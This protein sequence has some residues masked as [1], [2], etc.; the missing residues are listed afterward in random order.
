M[1]VEF[2]TESETKTQGKIT[3]THVNVV[4]QTPD[5]E[6]VMM[7]MDDIKALAELVE[8]NEFT[9]QHNSYIIRGL[10]PQGWKTLKGSNAPLEDL[11]EYYQDFV[12]HTTK[13]KGLFQVQVIILH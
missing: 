8:N 4:Q 12:K 9:D 7:D 13:F 10:T 2:N 3:T 1:E 5:G 6:G 11:D